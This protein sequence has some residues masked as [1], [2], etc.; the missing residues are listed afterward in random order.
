MIRSFSC[1]E[2]EKIWNGKRSKAFPGNIQS[3]ALRKLRMIHASRSVTDLK[4]PPGNR[5]E[6]LSGDRKGQKSIRINDQWRI[7][8][9]WKNDDAHDVAIVDYH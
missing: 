7:C 6:N 1:A 9:V 3:R 4:N 5:L 2:T 8:F